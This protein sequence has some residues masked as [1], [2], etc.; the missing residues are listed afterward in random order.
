M[1]ALL[2]E[3]GLP[4]GVLNVVPGGADAGSAI[5]TDP[6]VDKIAFTGSTG[7]GREIARNAAAT[8][9]PV[10]V[11]LGGKSANL[12]FAD[13]DPDAAVQ[14]AINGFTYNTG[15]F[16][17][18]GTR[19][20]V[21]QPVYEDVVAALSAAAGAIP[22]GDP[23]AEGTIIGPMTGAK[24]L[25]RVTGFV[26]RARANG[27]L[28]VAGGDVPSPDLGGGYYQRPV[29]VAD[30]TQDSE[31]V[32]Q[33]IFGPV[34]TVQPFDDEDH[35]IRLANS[36]SFGLA[37]GLQTS[38]MKRAHRVAAALKAGTVWVNQW[39]LLDVQM[40]IGGY[41]QS[42]YGRE[43]GPEG[44]AEYLQAKSVLIASV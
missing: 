33:E 9:K 43:N 35:A 1:A 14:T 11:E 40:P 39:G 41:K 27:S 10:T 28:R 31:L 44:L 32:Q 12:I 22:V 37:G 15:Q 4:G 18:A 8:L 38:D 30:V 42:G 24:Q 29:V 6:R 2:A 36:T 21:E 7:I 23:F 16:C 20:L 3:A 26:D 19:I 17:M 13:A 5:V 25:A 34:V